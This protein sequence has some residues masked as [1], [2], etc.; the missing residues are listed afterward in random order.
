MTVHS[1]L[2]P[3][4]T[5]AVDDV[6]NSAGIEHVGHGDNEP[7]EAA[8]IAAA[9]PTAQ[10]VI[11]P[12]R[13]R[14]VAD[15]VEATAAIG[16]PML[17][18]V[19]TWVGVTRDDEPG[20]EDDPA[21]HRGTILRMVA[22]DSVVAQ[23]ITDRVR[24]A[25]QRAMVV[26]GD[27]E[28]GAQLDAQLAR[29]GLPRT[30]DPA[31]ADVIVLAGLAGNP[32]IDAARALAP[33]PIIAFDGIQR[34]RFPHQ[35]AVIALAVA[36]SGEAYGVP[37]ARRAAELTVAALR[38]GGD[39]LQGLRELGPFDDHGDLIDPTVTFEPCG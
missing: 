4:L 22:R 9:D 36:T 26:A 30:N 32:E 17:V 37:E 21:M 8:T 14:D 34:E 25:N 20:C 31:D 19:A 2:P 7:V 16:L 1:I 3:S 24:Q 5:K 11:G 33:L 13:S 6:L 39:T 18:P 28:Y 10:A 29:S 15:A 35:D 27:H 12:F 23:R 38:R